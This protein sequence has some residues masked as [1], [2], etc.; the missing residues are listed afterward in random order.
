MVILTFGHQMEKIYKLIS[1]K[2]TRLFSYGLVFFLCVFSA[3]QSNKADNIRLV[4]KNGQA[5]GILMPEY[6]IGD[7]DKAPLTVSLNGSDHAILGSFVKTDTGVLF[8]PLI[9]L[10]QGM[11]YGIL[12]SNRMVGK[13]V[14]PNSSNKSPLVSDIYPQADTVPEN[15][16]KFYIEFSEPMQTGKALEYVFLLDKKQD[17]LDRIFLNLQPE[18]WDATD[19]VLTLWMDPGRIKRDLVL[20]KELG[21]PLHNKEAYELVISGK[22][23]DRQGLALG[24]DV[25]KKFFVG[26]RADVQPDV[27]AWQIIIPK[28]GSIEPLI[29]D[30]EYPLDHY[31]LEESINIFAEGKAIGGKIVVGNKDKIV[32][33]VPVDK[34]NAGKYTL[35]VN[36]RLE[37]LAG[38]NFNKIFDRD[39][40]KQKKADNAYYERKFELK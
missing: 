10:T 21:N 27:N 40:Y 7:I 23:K 38:N 6:L 4:W 37:D 25:R 22:W 32:K 11:E 24:K 33:F 12:Q 9:P 34:W 8:E 14:V 26:T 17:T 36:G 2:G 18:L 39:I 31:L 13:I 1:I 5:K 29:I 20:N 35:R 16:L 15:L 28:A 3:C 19:R 30:V